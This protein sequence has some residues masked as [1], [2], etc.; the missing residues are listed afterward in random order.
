M[1]QLKGKYCNVCLFIFLFFLSSEVQLQHVY[2]RGLGYLTLSIFKEIKL[3]SL[4]VNRVMALD[5]A[6]VNL[7]G[8]TVTLYIPT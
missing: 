7:S 1:L 3:A 2:G 6:A 4:A 5:K 8:S